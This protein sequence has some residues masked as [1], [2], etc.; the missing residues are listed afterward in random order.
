MTE[1]QKQDVKDYRA[2]EAKKGLALRANFDEWLRERG[3]QSLALTALQ[4]AES[5]SES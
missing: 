2:R 5:H 4:Y 3:V 1:A